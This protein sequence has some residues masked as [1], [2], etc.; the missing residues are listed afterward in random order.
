[1]NRKLFALV[2]IFLSTIVLEP[3]IAARLEQGRL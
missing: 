1:M 2:G 3:T